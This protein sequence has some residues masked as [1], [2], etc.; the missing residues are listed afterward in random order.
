MT[1]GEWITLIK[2]FIVLVAVGLFAVMLIQF[3]EDRVKRQDVVALQK[4]I[5]QN[6]SIESQW[7]QESLNATSTGQKAVND[8]TAALAKQPP[9]IVR[10]R[11]QGGPVPAAA[12]AAG[13][14][15]AANPG[16][17]AAGSGSAVQS[18]DLRPVLN[19]FELKYGT[20]LADCRVLYDAWPQAVKPR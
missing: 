14:C 13:G 8:L 3:G 17:A 1:V 2:D 20:A 12:G 18:V 19:A 4:Q 5:T 7:H 10:V 11:P 16:T 6:A 15:T 9:V